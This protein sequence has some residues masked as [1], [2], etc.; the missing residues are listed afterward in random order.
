M[1]SFHS[2]KPKKKHNVEMEKKLKPTTYEEII[3]LVKTNMP[4][5]TDQP[6][7]RKRK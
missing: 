7:Q 6:K 3:S 5:K 1:L 2:A 4:P